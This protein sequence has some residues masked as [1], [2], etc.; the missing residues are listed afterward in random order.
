MRIIQ[1]QIDTG[2]LKP[3]QRVPSVRAMSN[4]TGFSAVTVHHAYV[5]LESEGV[6][7]VRP[8]SGFFVAD[9]IRKLGEFAPREIEVEPEN[10]KSFASS[11]Y[12]LS[13]GWQSANMSSFGMMHVCEHLFPRK[14]FAV[15]HI[16]ALKQAASRAPVLYQSNGGKQLREALAKRAAL[17]GMAVH[18]SDFIITGSA[19]VSLDLCLEATTR[20]GD[21][22]LVESPS[23]PSLISALQRRQHKLIEIYSH[24]SYGVDPDQFKY[25]LDH[26]DIKACAL[27]TAHHFPTGVSYSED[28]VARI[29]AA[30]AAR[31]TPIIENDMYGELAQE[32][33]NR[34]TLLH[35]D[36]DGIVLQFGSFREIVGSAYVLGWIISRNRNFRVDE[37]NFFN[38]PPSE[39]VAVQA[40]LAEFILK[41]SYDRHLRVLRE[42]LGTRMRRGL[43]IISQT[44]PQ[45]CAV[46]RPDG[47]FMCWIKAPRGFDAIEM[48]PLAHKLGISYAPGPIFSVT[49]SF[50]NFLAINLSLDWTPTEVQKLGRLADLLASKH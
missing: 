23:H 8:R 10:F 5:E 48:A 15:L 44:F 37:A 21:T 27:M 3:G 14:E 20:P 11:Y 34:R 2:V 36:E 50:R 22:V 1:M 17:R 9:T 29:L 19:R 13:Q 18:P 24:P 43:N 41:R 33:G 32:P 4:R 46:S 25:L 40:A 26:N 12:R 16:K 47:G 35:M 6:L 28:A 39:S 49:N 45:E 42:T 30:A 38:D 31:K 7:V